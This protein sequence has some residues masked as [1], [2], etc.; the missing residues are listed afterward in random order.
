MGCR[1]L[2]VFPPYK[3]IK[4]HFGKV[5]NNNVEPSRR[6]SFYLINACESNAGSKCKTQFK[7]KPASKKK[8]L[9]V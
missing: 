2:A 6:L 9:N 8:N 3:K 7:R 1:I 5:N 4:A